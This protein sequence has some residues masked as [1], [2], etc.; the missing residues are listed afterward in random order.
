[1]SKSEVGGQGKP[2][3]RR[4]YDEYGSCI[5][6]YMFASLLIPTKDAGISGG[7]LKNKACLV[8]RGYRQE[9]GID[10]KESFAL[11]ARLDAIRI[12]LAYEFS[13]GTVDPTLFIKRKG[14]DIL[15][16]EIGESSLIGP[17][18]VQE[19]T[20]KVVLIKNKLKAARDRHKSYAENRRKPLDFEVG[21]RIRERVCPVAYRLR[22]PEEFSG[23]HET[24]H[25]SNLKKCLTDASFHVPL[26]E[27][28]VDKTLRFVEDPVSN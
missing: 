26:D 7:I 8:A 23:V 10:F 1:M 2:K 22:L 16:D 11:V 24:F 27:I 3:M 14:K 28:K 25:V 17:E 5:V 20:D 6:F 18:L 9:E 21:D 15:L 19:T 12:F 4:G 13:K